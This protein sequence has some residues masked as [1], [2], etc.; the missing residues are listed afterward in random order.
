MAAAFLIALGSFL[1]LGLGFGAVRN[2]VLLALVVGV[3]STGLGFLFALLA[4]RS[5]LP[6][7]RFFG[8]VSI[9]PIITP[10][11]MLGLA[12]IYLFGR[13]GYVTHSLF[14]LS[15]TAFLGMLGVALSV[16]SLPEDLVSEL[17][18]DDADRELLEYAALLHDV[19]CAVAQS[20]HHKHSL[21]I[22][23][24]AEIAGFGQHELLVMANVA[25]YHR[26]ALPAAHH[27]DYVELDE[28][29]R[30][31]V[32]RLGALLRLA[33]ALDLDRC[34]VVD[35][36]RVELRDGRVDLLLAA[37]DEP[38]LPLWAAERNADLFTQEF[39]LSLRPAVASLA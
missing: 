16:L 11:F 4:D 25:R 27:R 22:I 19:G 29:D 10:P 23:R 24:N 15:T 32:R 17:G 7:R 1:A 20:A 13:R 30:R 26:K 31:R 18:L 37:R 6:L 39:G 3:L 8:P 36:V 12:I 9:L 33:D 35:D 14:G 34:Q 2:S 38:R 21:Y 5:R 28:D